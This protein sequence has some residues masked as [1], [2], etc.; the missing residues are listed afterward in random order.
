[1]VVGLKP[2]IGGFPYDRKTIWARVNPRKD[3]RRGGAV[4]SAVENLDAPK[5]EFP[6]GTGGCNDS[7]VDPNLHDALVTELRASQARERKLSRQVDELSRR[8]ALLSDE[9]SHRLFNGLQLIGTLLSAQSRL[10]PAET[11]T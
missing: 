2:A 3:R 11:A 9:L 6:L 1:L 7:T 5:I 4:T 10:A 8:D